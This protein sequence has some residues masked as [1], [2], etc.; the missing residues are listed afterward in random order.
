M[1]IAS[2]TDLKNYALRELGYPVISI[3]LETTQMEDRIDEALQMWRE[4]HFDAIERSYISRQVT[5]DEITVTNLAGTFQY[6]EW[7]TSS[8]TGTSFQFYDIHGAIIRSRAITNG[9]LLAGE[10][11]TGSVSNATAEVVS[12]ALGDISNRYVTLPDYVHSVTRLINWSQVTSKVS[13]FDLRYQWRLNDVFA[14]TDVNLTY[15]TQMQ[16]HLSLLDQTLVAQPS[17]RFNRHMNKVYIDGDMNYLNPGDYIVLEV[18]AI[19]DP[20]VY[21]KVYSDRVLKKLVVAY[22][23]RQWGANLSKFDGITLPG[24]IKLRGAEIYQEAL[25]EISQV[26][27]ELRSSFEVPSGFITG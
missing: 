14:L 20:D 24:G 26:E 22:F 27:E 5:I 11:L 2:R 25:L 19:I 21:T 3:D 13:M 6:N 16:Q 12:V 7:I 4:Y 8:V 23:K 17:L 9:T 1:T 10:V 15:Y 18:Y